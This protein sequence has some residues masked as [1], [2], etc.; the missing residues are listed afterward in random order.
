MN[1]KIKIALCSALTA[2]SCFTFGCTP[3][4]TSA[5]VED[6]EAHFNISY[7]FVTNVFDGSTRNLTVKDMQAFEEYLI[8][9][10]GYSGKRQL[11]DSEVEAFMY[12]IDGSRFYIANINDDKYHMSACKYTLYVDSDMNAVKFIYPPVSGDSSLYY[13]GE[14]T[15]QVIQNWDYFDNF[16]SIYDDAVIDGAAQTI[17][18]SG[19]YEDETAAKVT[20]KYENSIIYFSYAIDGES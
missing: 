4:A 5:W 9:V 18:V 19:S 8:S 3:K 15:M 20:L 7:S 14:T 1:K 6:G 16:Y 11:A 2:V 10:E 17:T 12:Y 13:K